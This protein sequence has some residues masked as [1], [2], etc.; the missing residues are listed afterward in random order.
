MS[1]FF[2]LVNQRESC[3]NYDPDKSPTKEQLINCI[4]AAQLAPSACNS[5]PWSFIVINDPELSKDAA[6]CMQIR[7]L[8]KF[9]EKCPSF[10]VVC[11]EDAMLIGRSE[12]DQKYAS[13]DIGIAVAHLCYA[14]TQQGL[15]TCIMGAFDPEAL[16]KVLGITEPKRVRLV[17][18]VG[19]AATEQLRPKRRKE[20]EEIMTYL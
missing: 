18:A 1:D 4:K 5:Q 13:I 3:R 17:I 15:S 14:A 6:P 20:L 9:T 7:G 12:P 8:N 19:Y 16:L 2:Q 10:I 11:E